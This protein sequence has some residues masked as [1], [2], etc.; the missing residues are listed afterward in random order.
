MRAARIIRTV[1]N[2]LARPDRHA[3]H[4]EFNNGPLRI[5]CRGRARDF[6]LDHDRRKDRVRP[7]LRRKPQQVRGQV[8]APLLDLP[9]RRPASP[10]NIGDMN[11]GAV[12]FGGDPGLLQRRR[13]DGPSNLEPPREPI[14][15]DVRIA[16]HFDARSR[17]TTG[18]FAGS[19]V[20][21]Q[22]AIR[23]ALTTREFEPIRS[24]DV[25][26]S[27]GRHP[28]C[29]LSWQA[30]DE[31]RGAPLR[32]EAPLVLARRFRPVRPRR[33]NWIVPAR[34]LTL[35]LGAARG[36][37]SSHGGSSARSASVRSG[38]SAPA[39]RDGRPA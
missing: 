26:R 15:R 8:S 31:T 35:S 14:R 17:R 11:A 34:Q 24:Q 4:D 32:A 23:G 25:R 12:T 21:G 7:H 37:A 2:V 13:P 16:V 27:G 36:H 9:P 6:R 30:G 18:S 33:V 10:R 3:L 29:P 19:G 5:G 1:V 20:R 22:E 28:A 39:H 38:G